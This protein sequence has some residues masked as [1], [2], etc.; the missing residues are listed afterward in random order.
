MAEAEAALSV[1]E[2]DAPLPAVQPLLDASVRERW[3]D[4][5]IGLLL[6]GDLKSAQAAFLKV[7]AM[8]PAYPDGPVNVART[9]IQEGEVDAAIPLLEQAL[10]LSPRLAKAHYFLG[11]ALKTLGRYDEAI[12]HLTIAAEQ[13][14]RDRV[15]LNEI[16]RVRFFQRQFDEAIAAFKRALAVVGRSRRALQSDARLPG[17]RRR[18]ERGRERRCIPGSRPTRKR[19]RSPA[20]IG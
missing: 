7:M 4:Y 12:E 17:S 3:N 16:G 1:I 8:D 6:Q 13:Y 10:E 5:G 19:K 18:G 15:V 14:P 9:R 11:T 20:R 2:A